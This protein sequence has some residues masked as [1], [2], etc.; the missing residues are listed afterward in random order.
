M[1]DAVACAGP[2]PCGPSSGPSHPP[3]CR[4][5]AALLASQV[6]TATKARYLR[7]RDLIRQ[8]VRQL[9][10]S[11]ERKKS[12]LADDSTEK[13]LASLEQRLG[14]YEQ[15][16]FQLRECTSVVHPAALYLPRPPRLLTLACC[17]ACAC[18]CARRHRHEG[19][20]DG[21]RVHRGGV[22]PTDRRRE[23][24]HHPCTGN[25]G[26]LA[27]HRPVLVQLTHCH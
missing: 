3:L 18:A 22:P 8:Q 19:Q 11:Y 13:T 10:A 4:R 5:C 20:G 6:L 9:S 2:N 21:A 15:K 26:T 14:N 16:I 12:L 27:H 25:H 7:R 17:A 24:V 1:C 23:R